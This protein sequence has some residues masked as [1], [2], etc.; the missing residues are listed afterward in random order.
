MLLSAYCT[1]G[2]QVG[3]SGLHLEPVERRGS[4]PGKVVSEIRLGWQRGRVQAHY[5]YCHCQLYDL[6]SVAW[7]P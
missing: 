6:R 4:T 5:G 2:W 1:V 7:P 3:I